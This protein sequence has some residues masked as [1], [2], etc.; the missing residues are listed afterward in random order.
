MSFR[1]YRKRRL[2]VFYVFVGCLVSVLVFMA[3]IF[4]Y[5]S[6]QVEKRFSGQRWSIPS[7]I[8]SDTVILFPGIPLS[9]ETLSKMLERRFYRKG[10]QPSIRPGEYWIDKTRG[11]CVVWFRAFKFPGKNIKERKVHFKI[12]N[13]LLKEI[14]S[15]GESLPYWE[16][17]PVELSRLFGTEKKQRLLISIRNVSPFLKDAV[18]AIEDKRF[19]GHP[20]LDILGII[21][22][23]IVD[24]RAKKIVQGGSTITQ[25]L[26]KNYFLEPER[27]FRRKL[28]EAIISLIIELRY[29]KDE[30]MEMYLNEIYMGQRGGIEIRGMG[31]AARIYFGKNVE[32]LNLSEAATLAGMIK[33]PN[34]YNPILHPDRA[35]ARRD[36]VLEAMAEQGKIDQ[37]TMKTIKNKPIETFHG[38]SIPIKK[39]PYFVDLV[40]EQLKQLYDPKVLESEGLVI[41]TSLIPEIEDEAEQALRE[42]LQKIEASNPHLKDPEGELLQ[43]VIISVQPKTGMV[44]ALVGG[45]DYSVSIFNR[46]TKAMR[47]PG[48]VIKPFIY[49]EAIKKGWTLASRLEDRPFTIS[50]NGT[51][52]ILENYD[53]NFRGS[54][55]LREALEQ[56]LD[57]PTVRL[58]IDVGL[59]DIGYLLR[60]INLYNQLTPYPSIAL[61]T[62]EV[63]P[64]NLASAYT[65]LANNGDKPYL[66]TVK[67]VY[68]ANGVLQQQHHI[69]WLKIASS[70]EAFLITSALEGVVKRG[71]AK[72]L[73]EMGITFPCAAK[74]G[75][76]NQLQD[77]WFVGYTTDMVALVWVGFD[78]DYP[79]GLT[80]ATGA[81]P[82]WGNFMKRISY[83]L[84]PQPFHPPSNIVE[85]PIC[86]DSGALSTDN[87]SYVYTE[88]FIKV[89][90]PTKPCPIHGSNIKKSYELEKGKES[91]W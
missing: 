8:F 89:H 72:S 79:M 41:Y 36:V 88:H 48:S 86:G 63:T 20:G 42:E 55:T 77:A 84:N 13:D 66:I 85:R 71:T 17:E 68:D 49:L 6:W 53:R 9:L 21:R 32:D 11:E 50:I 59:E 25:Q 64:L 23:L 82:V 24:L 22:A 18:V 5:F 51:P 69:E 37:E 4:F 43:G 30:I 40:F 39:A 83:L 33:A 91:S 67:E 10:F 70:E 74:T 61:G 62:M 73:S 46:A 90:E 19:Y 80:G 16:L 29:T 1:L 15:E 2:R 7:Y 75:T 81:M 3:G 78:K 35:K 45:R 44:R 54:V 27:T 58:A 65:A 28:L 60:K 26:V 56:S 52:W 34:L 38:L 57:V 76:T 87:C 14:F 47:Q 12:K 31:E